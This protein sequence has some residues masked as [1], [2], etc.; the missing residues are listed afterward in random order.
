MHEELVEL[1]L[2]LID[3]KCAIA[4]HKQT[5]P[6]YLYKQ[7]NDLQEQIR[8]LAAEMDAEEEN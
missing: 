2:M 4:A 5:P 8:E 6:N 1:L 7:V 3:T